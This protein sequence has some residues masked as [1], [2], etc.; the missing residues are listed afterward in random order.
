MALFDPFPQLTTSRLRLRAPTLADAAD[1][2]RHERD[3][4]IPCV[5]CS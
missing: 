2:H 1:F 3:P 5:R 4:Q